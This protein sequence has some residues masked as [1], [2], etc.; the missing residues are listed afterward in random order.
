MLG[1][2]AVASLNAVLALHAARWYLGP[3]YRLATRIHCLLFGR[4]I[5]QGW[6]RE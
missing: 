4:L 1:A 3:I 5:A 2:I 6:V